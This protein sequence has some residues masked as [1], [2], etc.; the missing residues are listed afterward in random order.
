MCLASRSALAA[1]PL[2]DARAASSFAPNPTLDSS[3]ASV[4]ATATDGCSQGWTG[5]VLQRGHAPTAPDASD[6]LP[7]AAVPTALRVLAASPTAALAVLAPTFTLPAGVRDRVERP[8]R[9]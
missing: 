3:S 8:P 6:S 2:C 1:A 7:R 5:K 9:A 4:D